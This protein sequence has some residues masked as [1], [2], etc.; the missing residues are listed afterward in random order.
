ML[1]MK[2]VGIAKL[3]SLIPKTI[4]YAITIG[5]YSVYFTSGNSFETKNW[6]RKSTFWK[7]P[8]YFL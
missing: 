3:I 1:K 7:D 5:E 2:G 8:F 6:L 4:H